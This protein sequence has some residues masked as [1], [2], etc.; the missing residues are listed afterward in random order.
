MGLVR[1]GRSRVRI[2]IF[3]LNFRG[4]RGTKCNNIQRANQI[5][6][7]KNLDDV[8]IGAFETQDEMKLFIETYYNTKSKYNMKICDNEATKLFLSKYNL[9]TFN[10]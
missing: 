9:N 10:N 4:I 8:F 5:D 1:S 6:P 2:I 3:M 7:K